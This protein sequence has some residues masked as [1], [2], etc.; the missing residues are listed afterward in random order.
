MSSPYDNIDPA[1]NPAN[2]YPSAA[3]ASTDVYTGL[4]DESGLPLLPSTPSYLVGADNHQLGNTGSS[5]FDP[6]TWGDRA[7]HAFSK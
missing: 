5:I 2:S 3:P 6:T 1:F 4:Q 7:T